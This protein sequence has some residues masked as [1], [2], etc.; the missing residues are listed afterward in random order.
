M[1][2]V[3]IIIPVYNVEKYLNKCIDSVIEQ[4]YKELDIILVDDG[5]T[6]SCGV[7]CDEYAKRDPRI[8]VIHQENAG[9]GYARNNGLN[10]AKGEYVV[11]IDSDDYIHTDLVKNCVIAMQ[12]YNTDMVLYSGNKVDENGNF[13]E[14]VSYPCVPLERLEPT[15]VLTV[16]S[17]I[18]SPWLFMSKLSV[19]KESGVLFPSKV[20]YEDLRTIPKWCMFINNAVKLDAEP[21]Y[22]YLCR[23]GSTMN[24]DNVERLKK[25]RI[26]AIDDLYHWFAKKGYYEEN[27]SLIDW[28]CIYHG[29]LLPNREVLNFN[30]NSKPVL[31]DL[32]EYTFSRVG[33][34]KVI[35]K[36]PYVSLL[37]TTEKIILFLALYRGYG[38][39]KLLSKVK[40]FLK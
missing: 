28:I 3:S 9:Q 31:N 36:N 1:K 20:W 39:I 34:K 19:L 11:F 7:V 24:N 30:C 14:C 40:T 35:L 12:E 23:Q 16:C 25:D 15:Q 4:S 6:D 27:K 18:P 29:F 32:R 21:M 2:L 38:F 10:V 22:Y 17:K 37:S 13:L 33:G 5:S 26:A 8:R